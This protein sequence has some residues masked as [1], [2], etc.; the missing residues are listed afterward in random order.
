[1]FDNQRDTEDVR[2]P[3]VH[4][5]RLVRPLD[6]ST[7]S[8]EDQ[9]TSRPSTNLTSSRRLDTDLASRKLNTDLTSSKL[10][11][12]LISRKQES[13]TS[14]RKIL[15]NFKFFKISRFFRV[16][17]IIYLSILCRPLLGAKCQGSPDIKDKSES[18]LNNLIERPARLE[19]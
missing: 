16:V 8:S 17:F 13:S 19:T 7:E 14:R 6:Q 9:E 12:D 10:D 4:G 1:M 5:G 15:I 18:K 11:T 2:Q 3:T